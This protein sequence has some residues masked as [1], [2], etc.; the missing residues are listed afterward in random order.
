MQSI[1]QQKSIQSLFSNLLSVKFLKF[2]LVLLQ[3]IRIVKPLIHPLWAL[4][5]SHATASDVTRGLRV[6]L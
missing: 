3:Y 4:E 2:H 5:V 6:G 1:I